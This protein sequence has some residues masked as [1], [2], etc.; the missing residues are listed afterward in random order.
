MK[1]II[2]CS[3][4]IFISAVNI[5]A[6]F[7]RVWEKSISLN[8][9]PGWF[10]PTDN[11]ER[12]FA[13]I[14]NQGNPRLLVI[15]NRNNP[16]I[17]ILDAMTG[18]SLGT[19]NTDG[20]TGGLIPLNDI[21]STHL[22][23]LGEIIYASN[24]TENA[25][26]SPFKVYKWDSANDPPETVIS[27]SL[28]PLRLG[29]RV[30]AINDLWEN[31]YRI[32]VAS[33]G[34]NKLIDYF[35]GTGSPPFYR[36]EVAL[37]DTILGNNASCDFN[38]FYP[39]DGGNYFVNSDGFNP[40]VYDT[41]GSLY[42]VTADSILSGQNNSIKYHANG[43]ICC[44]NPFY[45]TFQYE[46]NNAA[47]IQSGGPPWEFFWDETPSLGNN[48]NTKNFGDVEYL[49]LDGQHLYI[50]VLAGNNGIGCYFAEGME[51]PVE[52]I[53]F[54]A[55]VDSKGILLKWETGSEL[56]NHGFEIEKRTRSKS[57]NQYSE[58]IKLGFVPGFGTT[59]DRKTYSYLD[60]ETEEG[61]FQYR[62]KQLDFDGTFEYSEIAE[63]ENLP[64]INFSLSQNYPNPFNPSTIIKYQIPFVETGHAPSVRLI[65]YDVL[66]NEVV[67][68][69]DEEKPAGNY[70]IEFS[71]LGGSA[72]GGN[73]YTLSSGI[74]FYTLNAGTFVQTKK[75]IL[76]R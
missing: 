10:S 15:S 42:G 22:N 21:S 71:A 13:V 33:S 43:T 19:M 65:V 6:Q 40:K 5:D 58:W 67:V 57:N 72:S 68:L 14:E 38:F 29:D 31:L 70:E 61:I 25:Q 24:L 46:S 47:L 51:L 7:V 69:V 2:F 11:R 34:T 16:T 17:I 52:L 26:S 12:G 76:L 27:D 28:S 66:G 8:N 49:W 30:N 44:D 20:I 35:S 59:S 41:T 56:N 39:Q 9:L 4:I 53:S 23:Y 50:F 37:N 45:T 64:V 55:A 36:K 60:E 63:V 18:D 73:A 48:P 75:M 1:K 3:F 74:Y 54:N 62:L 32:T